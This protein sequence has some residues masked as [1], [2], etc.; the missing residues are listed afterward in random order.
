MLYEE[1]QRP[2]AASLAA[3]LASKFHARAEAAVALDERPGYTPYGAARR[4][5]EDEQSSEILLSGPSGTGKSRAMLERCHQL[6]QRH[7]KARGLIVR[8][9][10]ASLT[11]SALITMNRYVRTPQDGSVWKESRSEYQYPNGSVL[12]IAGIDKPERIMSTE[13]DFIYVMEA[14]ELTLVEWDMLSTRLR[15]DAMSWHPMFADCNPSAPRHWLKLRFDA[16]LMINYP[17]VHEDNPRLYDHQIE[18]WTPEGEEYI[19]RLER[20]SGVRLLRLRK[21]LWAAAEG[22]IYEE[23]NPAV[24]LLDWEDLPVIDEESGERGI[25]Y[26]WPRYWAIDFGYTRPFVF[27]AWAEDPDGRLY[28][29]CEL[30]QTRRLVE[31]HA[32]EIRRVLENDPVPFAII[33]D[34]DA[35]D[36]ATFERHLE[37]Y[38]RA[39]YK[40]VLPGIQAVQARLRIAGDGRP[41]LY[42]MRDA[43]VS[44]DRNLVEAASPIQTA[45][46]IEAYVW[47]DSP[48][49]ERSQK[50]RPRKADDH[51]MDAM[52]YL[53]A[54][55]DSLAAE[56]ADYAEDVY[57]VYDKRVRIGPQI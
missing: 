47:D 19:A 24:H 16:G 23:W 28:L 50:E 33:V 49:L 20:L 42:L 46:E 41:R 8:K 26:E 36:R 10:R 52:R 12:V 53:V 1:Q 57:Y 37:L 34:H 6:L 2:L 43:L 35:E 15:N 56:L 48:A 30:Y 22:M 17:S 5:F 7:P 21:G 3:S 51:G 39:A 11:Q 44:V 14:T 54:Y 38:T 31:E 4:L 25:P 40:A 55:I 29:Y 9:T 45:D 13:Y 27:Q 32:A 18:C